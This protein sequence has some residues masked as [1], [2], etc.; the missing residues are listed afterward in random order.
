[1]ISAYA[2]GATYSPARLRF[3]VAMWCAR[4]HRP[5]AIADDPEF[6]DIAHMLYSK[7]KI[8]SRWTVGRD[9]QTIF[10]STKVRVR[11]HLQVSL[12]PHRQRPLDLIAPHMLLQNLPGAVHICLDGWT[13]PNVISFLGVT[14]HWHERGEINHIILDFIQYV[15]VSV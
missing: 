7:V 8:P 11:E 6:H 13:S 10:E 3:L 12:Q 9:V 5:F 1:M 4:R 14:A 2:S 15:C